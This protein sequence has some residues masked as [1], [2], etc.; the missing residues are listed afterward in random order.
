MIYKAVK[1]EI[2]SHPNG[3]EGGGEKTQE[4]Q[5][6][7]AVTKEKEK[8]T[9]TK[10][11]RCKSVPSRRSRALVTGRVDYVKALPSQNGEPSRDPSI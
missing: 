5:V 7:P 6:L 1:M 3:G 2:H 4:H 10:A 9:V 11:N 8:Q